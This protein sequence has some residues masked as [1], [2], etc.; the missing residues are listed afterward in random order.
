[1]NTSIRKPP[2][3]H[4]RE[5]CFWQSRVRSCDPNCG[6]DG[7]VRSSRQVRSSE[8]TSNRPIMFLR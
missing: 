4:D 3:G 1:M 2:A 6:G 8:W 5:N 7:D